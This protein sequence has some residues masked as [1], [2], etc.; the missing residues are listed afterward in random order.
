MVGA[1]D[2]DLFHFR[3]YGKGC[4]ADAFRVYRHFPIAQYFQSQLLGGTGEDVAAFFF[5]AYVAG[6][7]QHAYAVFTVGGQMNA[8]LEAFIEEKIMRCLDHDT[9]TISSIF[10]TAAGPTIIHVLDDLQRTCNN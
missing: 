10:I 7:E 8:Q 9:S 2:E 1:G 3:L 6:K 4:R 5:Q